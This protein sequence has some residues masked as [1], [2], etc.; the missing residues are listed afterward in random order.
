MTYRPLVIIVLALLS[1]SGTM[2]RKSACLVDDIEIEFKGNKKLEN[3]FSEI[4]IGDD[5]AGEKLRRFYIFFPYDGKVKDVDLELIRNGVVKEKF[6][7]KD[8]DR[9]VYRADYTLASDYYFYHW[10]F[11]SLKPGDLLK[12]RYRLELKN[13]SYGQYEPVLDIVPVDSAS[14]KFIFDKDDWSLK[15]QVDNGDVLFE[16]E[17]GEI[18][19]RWENLPDPKDSD[20]QNAP[21]DML[22][23]IWYQFISKKGKSDF[24]SWDKVYDWHTD[25]CRGTN[26][27]DKDTGLLDIART[28][29][30]IYSKIKDRCR[31]VAVEIDK[32]RFR[33]MPAAKVWDRGYG[34]CKALSNLFVNWLNLAGYEAWPVLVR[35]S[36]SYMGN[37]HFPS[38]YLFDHEIAAF[39]SDTGD[40]VFQELTSESIPFGEIPIELYGSFA[41]P[42]VEET[43]PIRLP[44]GRLFPDTLSIL[45]TGVLDSSFDL[46]GSAVSRRT[47]Q[48]AINEIWKI[49]NSQPGVDR[50]SRIRSEFER[51]MGDA[52]L[53]SV[54]ESYVG[55]SIIIRSATIREN[56]LGFIKDSLLVL[57][58]WNMSYFK[59]ETEPDRNRTWPTILR[60]NIV[61]RSEYR[62][63]LDGAIPG[64]LVWGEVPVDPEY[65]DFTFINDSHDDS[66]IVKA[67]I[68]LKPLTL[69]PPGYYDYVDE[70]S[71]VSAL[72][73][74]GAI[75]RLE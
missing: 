67:V 69:D 29:D 23:G 35:S 21:K 19:F 8:A 2:D 30:E 11:G 28:P 12:R 10:D 25:L 14:I 75:F 59:Y 65:F 7:I 9:V 5:N 15:Y 33:P 53:D 46:V 55:D 13:A 44:C 64:D 50:S 38:P 70:R 62:C 26:L 40:T 34:D 57:K 71:K 54:E 22:P 6:G 63:K 74:R 61:Y 51:I 60:R 24:S 3:H 56:N 37:D 39:I 68:G 27:T 17:K 18:E 45:V 41:L 72:L 58:P 32:G 16:D 31:Y 48:G 49:R 47:G 43:S 73:K 4:L 36:R 52:M 66:L 42:L 20:Y 1:V